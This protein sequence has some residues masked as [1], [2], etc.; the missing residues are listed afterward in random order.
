MYSTHVN[1]ENIVD[2]GRIQ[3][4]VITAKHNTQRKNVTQMFQFGAFNLIRCIITVNLNETAEIHSKGKLL[5]LRRICFT[6][7]RELESCGTYKVG[8][9]VIK[10]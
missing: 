2:V 6:R 1:S 10:L 8:N 7:Y 3:S 4:F 5:H 9:C